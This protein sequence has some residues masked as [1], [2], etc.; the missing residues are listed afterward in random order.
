M[1]LCEDPCPPPAAISG[2]F[3]EQ[4]QVANSTRLLCELIGAKNPPCP[5]GRTGAEPG[6]GRAQ[7]PD[8]AH[9]TVQSDPECR[10]WPLLYHFHKQLLPAPHVS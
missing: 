4:V 8:T 9:L 10:L 6:W 7:E 1:R 3:G 2:A 5:V